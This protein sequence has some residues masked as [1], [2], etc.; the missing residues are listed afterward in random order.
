MHDVNETRELKMGND[1]YDY[2]S[3]G[4]QRGL[5][6]ILTEAGFKELEHFWF[7]NGLIFMNK[8]YMDVMF[9]AISEYIARNPSATEYLE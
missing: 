5:R 3:P 6:L 2:V 4:Q 7:S 9:D 8:Q 1:T